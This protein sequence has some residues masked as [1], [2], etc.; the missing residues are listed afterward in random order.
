MVF[1]RNFGL[2]SDAQLAAMS[3]DDQRNTLIVEVAAQTDLGQD[4]QG[5]GN[6]DLIRTVLGSDVLTAG[7][8]PGMVGSYLRGVLLLGGFRGPRELN[9]MSLDDM[10]NTLIVELTQRTRGRGYQAYSNPELEGA[11]AVLVAVRQLGILD[12]ATLATMSAD[13]MRNA[14]I[15]EL[16]RQTGTGRRLQGVDNL[17]LAMI[18]LGIEPPR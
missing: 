7:R 8:A 17:H 14:L 10:R 9:Q 13:D 1:L 18:P 6:L 16:D 2:R 3:A 15:V 4:L 12:D 11:G 5:S